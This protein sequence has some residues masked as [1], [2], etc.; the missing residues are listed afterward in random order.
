MAQQNKF[1]VGGHRKLE[2]DDDG[3]K[4]IYRDTAVVTVRNN[5]EIILD[6]GGWGTATTKTCMNQAS[7]HHNLGFKVY[8]KDFKWFVDYKDTKAISFNGDTL[9]LEGKLK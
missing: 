5:A 4:Y 8:Q 2:R 9:T 1:N 6:T 7:Q 3:T